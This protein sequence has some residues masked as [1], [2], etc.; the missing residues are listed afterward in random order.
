MSKSQCT[1]K[2]Q[3]DGEV[4]DYYQT[5]FENDYHPVRILDLATGPG[6][7]ANLIARELPKA[8]VFAT[9]VSRDMV[10]RAK[11]LMQDLKTIE[12]RI[13]DMQ[14]LSSLAPVANAA[15][16][17]HFDVVT[18]CYGYMFPEENRSRYGKPGAC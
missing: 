7:P 15:P 9:D 13:V 2:T 11:L 17:E 16:E 10:D 18:C 6:E 5:M 3:F 12:Y 4:A 8:Q 1:D 14:D